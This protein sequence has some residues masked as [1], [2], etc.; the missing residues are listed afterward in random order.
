M[1]TQ[2]MIFKHYAFFMSE[3]V[4]KRSPLL[5][6]GSAAAAATRTRPRTTCCLVGSA[7]RWRSMFTCF[8]NI[9]CLA[10]ERTITPLAPYGLPHLG[11]FA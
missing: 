10:V 6:I 8:I 3:I 5:S 1:A 9:L 4:R 7:Y 2:W 11:L